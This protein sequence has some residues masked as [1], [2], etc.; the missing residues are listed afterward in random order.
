MHNN[1]PYNINSQSP[2]RFLEKTP[3]NSL[4]VPFLNC[5][6]PDARFIYLYRDPRENISSIIEGWQSGRFVTYPQLH[7]RAGPW[8][9]LLPE[10]WVSVRDLPLEEVAAFQ[11]RAANECILTDLAAM[12]PDRWISLSYAKLI[13]EP[14]A[15]IARLC[16]FA[17]IPLDAGL[18]KATNNQLKYS[19]YTV[20]APEA[21]KW[22]K[23]AEVLSRVLPVVQDLWERMQAV[24][25]Y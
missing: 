2:V 12:R 15:S 25:H 6:F 9:F 21:D 10:G 11:W 22:R 24:H 17:D 13:G 19:R 18:R 1:Q 4:R 20:S 8:S 23:N 16:K 7:V 5:I 3:K 14:E